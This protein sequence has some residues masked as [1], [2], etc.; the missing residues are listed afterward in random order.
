MDVFTFDIVHVMSVVVKVGFRVFAVSVIA[1]QTIIIDD[2]V[3]GRIS[4]SLNSFFA[5]DT[6]D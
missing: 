6:A 4:L 1:V 3:I 2:T 5:A